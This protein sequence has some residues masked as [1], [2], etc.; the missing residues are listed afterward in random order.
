MLSLS[1]YYKV[2]SLIP[3]CITITAGVILSLTHDGSN[4]K[5]EW[6]TDDGFSLTVVLTIL[7]S[8]FISFLSL[9]LL[10]NKRPII[11]NNLLLSFLTWVLLPGVICLFVIYQEILNFTGHSDIDGSYE[12]NRLLDGYILSV[13]ILHLL[14][15]FVTYVHFRLISNSQN[16]KK[17]AN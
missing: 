6:F 17:S 2:S 5:S 7:L 14:A 4:Y 9:L 15:L 8:G 11:K 12:G 16:R 13:A 1:K 3:F 10:L